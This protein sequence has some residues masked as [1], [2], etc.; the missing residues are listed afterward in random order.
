MLDTIHRLNDRNYSMN[1]AQALI[2]A[3]IR[4][5]EFPRKKLGD[6]FSVENNDW[7]IPNICYQ[8]WVNDKFGRSHFTEIKR[9]RERNKDITFLL[10]DDEKL[11]RYMLQSW[12]KHPIYQIFLDANFGPMKADIF[13]YCILFE[14]GGYY[15]DISKGCDA[16]LR[17]MHDSHTEAFI[18]FEN[19]FHGWDIQD[20]IKKRLDSPENLIIQW[21]FGFIKGH[22]IL[23]EVIDCI[24]ENE[25]NFR[26]KNFEVPKD[27]ILDYTGP[28]SFTRAVHNSISSLRHETLTQAGVDFLGNGSYALKGSYVRYFTKRPY[29]EFPF[30]AILGNSN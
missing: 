6:T 10:Y 13:R 27:A 19:N 12:G 7:R 28:R 2:S 15:F 25:A 16:P 20:S 14:K 11:N 24:V 23:K 4:V 29:T 22:P 30:S 1:I 18:S 26:G 8:T 9:F 17:S 3:R 5:N 21:G